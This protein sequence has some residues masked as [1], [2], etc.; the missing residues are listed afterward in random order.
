[1]VG[2]HAHNVPREAKANLA[3]RVKMAKLGYSSRSQ[4]AALRGMCQQ[5]VLFFINT[6]CWTVNP[7]W[8]PNCPERPFITHEFQE[9]AIR[10]MISSLARA[11]KPEHVGKTDLAF[12]KARGTG[13]SWVVLLFLLWRWLYFRSQS[14]LLVSRV[15]NLVDKPKDINALMPKLDF[16][17]ERLPSWLKPKLSPSDRVE[18]KLYNPLMRSIFSGQS[19]TGEF[20]RGGRPTVIVM[21]EFAFF[22]IGDSFKAFKAATGA[23]FCCWFVSTPNGVGN[24][25]HK[26]ITDDA[27]ERIDFRWEDMPE[28]RRGLYRSTNGQV[29]ILDKDFIHP[30][31][32][33]FVDDDRV[34]SVWYDAEERRTQMR[35][36][37]AQ[38]HDRDFVG[39][40]DPFFA[41]DELE[42]LMA[43]TRPPASVKTY[44]SDNG[45]VG[46]LRL[47]LQPAAF[48]SPPLDRCYVLG[49]DVSAGTGASNSCLCVFDCRLK[50]KV[51][52]L[53]DPNLDPFELAEIAVQV[54]RWFEDWTGTP[55]VLIWEAQG[56][57]RSFGKRVQ[58]LG[59]ENLY[60][61]GSGLTEEERKSRAPGLWAT[62]DSTQSLIRDYGVAL[63]SGRFAEPSEDGIRECHDYRY[64]PNGK[65]AHY[66]QITSED[67]SGARENHGDRVAANALA[68]RAS[69]GISEPTP[70]M[71]SSTIEPKH[72][73]LYTDMLESRKLASEKKRIEEGWLVG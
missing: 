65:V 35:S 55:A 39:S 25:F 11:G 30:S 3:F 13:G 67:A 1:M 9:H 31:S 63:C 6:F 51:A 24:A 14:F 44:R 4:A 60:Y 71:D 43:R 73:C 53:A 48:D 18:L 56:V 34:R 49:V 69:V 66:R 28:K 62:R 36:L 32:Y 15:E 47:W 7:M 52:E 8:H 21:D 40:G 46:K 61:S 70:N 38:E 42:K 23:S 2:E 5:D 64:F 22:D 12:F 27:I 50:E 20:A 68:L 54:G 45:S 41:S 29:K 16:V 57:G 33:P 17:L 10:R 59:Y 26:I 72:P 37:M 58:N 19:T